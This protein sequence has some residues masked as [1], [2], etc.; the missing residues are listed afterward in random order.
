MLA[1]GITI[2]VRQN[3]VGKTA[4]VEAL[5]LTFQHHPHRS[6]RTMPRAG[7]PPR[8]NS[9]VRVSFRIPRDE[10]LQ[11][12][13][14]LGD[15]WMPTTT[16]S[17]ESDAQELSTSSRD[18]VLLNTEWS[19]GGISWAKFSFAAPWASSSV[20]A[21]LLR[22][23]VQGEIE[24]AQNSLGGI[25][26]SSRVEYRSGSRFFSLRPRSRKAHLEAMVP[27]KWPWSHC[28]RQRCQRHVA[29][30]RLCP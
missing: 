12:L 27:Q 15:F 19:N 13:A 2:V 17:G 26:H 28:L 21:A 8:G 9:A 22:V 16:S 6:L 18:G 5:S 4:L 7:S 3:N 11:L 24:A 1:P 29:C 25:N 30:F 23:N 14:R 10:L 20:Q